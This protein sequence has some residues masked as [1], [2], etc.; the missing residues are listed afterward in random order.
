MFNCC[1]YWD[2]QV[3]S[4]CLEHKIVIARQEGEIRRLKETNVAK[5]SEH[6]SVMS[7]GFAELFL[8][9]MI[10]LDYLVYTFV[11]VYE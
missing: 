3:C 2:T 6:R 5:E 10:M 11:C 7:M 4:Q 8:L 1:C 9:I